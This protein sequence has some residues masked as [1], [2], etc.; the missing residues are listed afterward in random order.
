MMIYHA[1]KLFRNQSRTGSVFSLLQYC[2]RNYLFFGDLIPRSPM[3]VFDVAIV[4][5]FGA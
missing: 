4:V 5:A 2:E 1:C 3:I